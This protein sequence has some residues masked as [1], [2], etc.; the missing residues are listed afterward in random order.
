MTYVSGEPLTVAFAGTGTDSDG[1]VVSYEWEFGDGESS[2][3]QN[4]SHVY[5][6]PGTYTATLTVTDNCDT[7]GTANVTI[8]VTRP[9]D[10]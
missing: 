7:S 3:D 9:D 6:V 10:G 2:A 5:T 4:I 1:T 8:E